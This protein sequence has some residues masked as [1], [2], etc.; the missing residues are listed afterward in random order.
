MGILVDITNRTTSISS[1]K[2]SQIIE[3]CSAW[4]TKTYCSKRD[5]QSLLGSLLYITKYV[6]PV[7]YFLHCMLIL[8]REN[9][10]QW[11][12][13]LNQ[14]SFSDL[15]WFC[16]FLHTYNGI[17]Y[18]DARSTDAEVHLDACHTDLGGAYNSMVY[19][20]PNNYQGYTIVH[21]EI[22]NILVACKIWAK[23]WQDKKV[24]IFC[25]NLAVEVLTTGR[26]R[27]HTLA[28]CARNIWLLPSLYNIH[29]TFSHIAGKKIY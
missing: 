22:L 2:L 11:K 23:F 10:T 16:T 7:Q 17:T 9:S 1:E 5:L 27:D 28:A 21:L 3:T 29:L 25:D 8:L 18:Y 24:Q 26:T 13:L 15:N 6:K 19:A 4:S 12:I 20:L 14:P